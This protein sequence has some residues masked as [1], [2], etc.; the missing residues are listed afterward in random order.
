MGGTLKSS[1]YIWISHSKP[2]MWIYLGIPPMY[3]KLHII[4][5]MQRQGHRY[6]P[7]TALASWFSSCQG[8]NPQVPPP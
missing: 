7:G 6:Q 4:M 5:G 3:E 1:I 2:S 8:V